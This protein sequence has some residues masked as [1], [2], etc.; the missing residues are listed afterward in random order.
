MITV[1]KKGGINRTLAESQQ[2]DDLE[3]KWHEQTI[4]SLSQQLK[5]PL[6]LIHVAYGRELNRLN[7]TARIRT[8]LP[9][10]IGKVIRDHLR[11]NIADRS[12]S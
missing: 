6:E 7:P 5:M 3:L 9:I 4:I 10:L 8:Y 1:M 11:G 2:N 12:L